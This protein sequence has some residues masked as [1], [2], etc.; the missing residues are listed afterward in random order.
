MLKT[1]KTN[2]G[3]I[4]IARKPQKNANVEADASVCPN[5]TKAYPNNVGVGL[6]QPGSVK[7]DPYYNMGYCSTRKSLNIK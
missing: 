1:N 2:V 3:A 5:A 4:L 6:D 7:T